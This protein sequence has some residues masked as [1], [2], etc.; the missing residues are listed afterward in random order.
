[1]SALE[2]A[3]SYSV[4]SRALFGKDP[5][6][7]NFCSIADG[8]IICGGIGSPGSPYLILWMKYTIGVAT[9]TLEQLFG[10]SMATP[11][12]QYGYSV[13]NNYYGHYTF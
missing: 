6:R 10:Y 8:A 9:A 3:Q 7:P 12:Q 4:S 5:T 1:M 13:E 11:G 2:V